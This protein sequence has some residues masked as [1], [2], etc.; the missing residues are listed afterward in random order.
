MGFLLYTPIFAPKN[1]L[2]R[3]EG[4][5][6]IIISSLCLL[7]PVN[8]I[9]FVPAGLAPASTGGMAG[10]QASESNDTSHATT[11]PPQLHCLKDVR[12]NPHP[13][14]R[15]KSWKSTYNG[16]TSKKRNRC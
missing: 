7:T 13:L 10:V 15:L 5:T 1:Q 16:R 11:M 3:N 9:W 2:Y 8:I 6:S 14:T 4:Q 12:Q